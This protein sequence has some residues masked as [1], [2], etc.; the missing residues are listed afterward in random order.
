MIDFMLSV[1]STVLQMNMRD[2]HDIPFALPLLFFIFLGFIISITVL[3]FIG[4]EEKE[5]SE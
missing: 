4:N 2:H 3:K 5:E 1:F